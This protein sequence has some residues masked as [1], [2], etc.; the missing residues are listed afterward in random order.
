MWAAEM[1]DAA[2]PVASAAPIAC[3]RSGQSSRNMRT[4]SRRNDASPPVWRSSAAR[5]RISF[6][7]P[8]TP[9]ALRLV[10]LVAFDF[11]FERARARRTDAVAELCVR[12]LRDV[13][14]HLDPV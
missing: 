14:L 3:T 11:A 10:V 5:S 12:P 1:S 8:A 4:T 2:S 7:C 13:R 9:L 6:E